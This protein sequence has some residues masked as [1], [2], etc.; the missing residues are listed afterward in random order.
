MMSAGAYAQPVATTAGII[1]GGLDITIDCSLTYHG[2]T[3]G[4]IANQATGSLSGTVCMDPALGT[5][6]PYVKLS[7]SID[8]SSAT[9][10]APYNMDNGS[11]VIETDWGTGTGWTYYNTINVATTNIPCTSLASPSNPSCQANL[12]GM[13]STLYLN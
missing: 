10:T 6:A 8:D 7:L 1:T 3:S 13:P 2:G 9:P 5:G 11:I 12:L 4:V